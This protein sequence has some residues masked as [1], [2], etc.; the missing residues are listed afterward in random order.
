LQTEASDWSRNLEEI[1][2]QGRALFAD[3]YHC[4]RFEDLLDR[5]L[6][7]LIAIWDFLQVQPSF[8]EAE[9]LIAESINR[10]PGA[11]EHVRKESDLVD[12]F[13]RGSTGGW[14]DWFTPQDR[15]F[16]IEFAGQALV[17]WGYEEE[18]SS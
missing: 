6:D 4:L 10:N 15:Q 16:Y 7:A 14:R 13:K 8:P 11:E 12:G 5:P 3:Q 9:D 1:D 2:R 18:G 17:D